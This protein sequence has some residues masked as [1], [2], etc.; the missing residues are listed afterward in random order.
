MV[1]EKDFKQDLA[2]IRSMMERSSKFLSLSGW[3]GILAGIY[4]IAGVW[5]ANFYYGFYPDELFY[6]TPYM[7]SIILIACM[8]MVLALITAVF[9]SK[10]KAAQKGESVWNATSKRMLSNMLI[11]LA[12]GGV[13][14]SLFMIKELL[15]LVPALMLIFYG[16]S[17]I[18][19]GYFTLSEVRVMGF[20]QLFLGLL[21]AWF[22]EYSLI[23]W[24]IGFG[25]V[26]IGYGL[27]MHIK[28]ER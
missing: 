4:A 12:A 2:E 1:P 21:A 14:I 17:L 6:S 16:F 23:I 3:S 10:R 8:V 28:Y 18:L 20:I 13:L 27:Y 9:F 24:T 19:G 25:L 7:S 22:I 5:F 15:G 11:P 26:H